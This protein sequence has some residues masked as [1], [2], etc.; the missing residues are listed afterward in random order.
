MQMT[1]RATKSSLVSLGSSALQLKKVINLTASFLA[2][3]VGWGLRRSCVWAVA[4]M[5]AEGSRF[6]LWGMEWES[7]TRR[8]GKGG[9]GVYD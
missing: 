2:E 9:K 3:A 1:Q 8:K 5:D 7:S 6:P 4:L